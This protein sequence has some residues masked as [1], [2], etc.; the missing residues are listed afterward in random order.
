[1]LEDKLPQR[2]TA[3]FG[4]WATASG[5]SAFVVHAFGYLALRQ[6]LKALGIETDLSVVDERYLF[7][8]LR[9]CLHL[10]LSLPQLLLLLGVP[11]LVAWILRKPAIAIASRLHIRRYGVKRPLVTLLR[12]PK[13][14]ALVGIG[15]AVVAIQFVMRQIFLFDQLLLRPALPRPQWLAWVLLDDGGL[16]QTFYFG[17]LLL[18]VI[19]TM[20]LLVTAWRGGTSVKLC[21]LL[22]ALV[23]IQAM[24][25]PITYGSLTTGREVPRIAWPEVVGSPPGQAWLVWETDDGLTL[26]VRRGDQRRIVRI[27]KKEVERLETLCVD[28]LL[29]VLYA[30]VASCAG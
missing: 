2:W 9:F 6:H 25:L 7:A 8:G 28:P 5:F 15:L 26:L 23:L 12:A 17:A 27:D 21:V 11:A 13:L 3:L 18:L 29:R 1:M 30:G 19:V 16:G 20:T 24:L 22:A 4:L 14:A 10:V